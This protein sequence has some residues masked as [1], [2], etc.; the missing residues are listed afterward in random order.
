[1]ERTK[2]L[3]LLGLANRAGK[4]VS[5][6]SEVLHKLQQEKIMMVFVAN[7]ASD[8]TKQTFQNKCTHYKVE[9][10]LDFST[11]E[12]SHA[13]GKEM[14]KILAVTDLGFYKTLKEKL[15]RGE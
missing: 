11:E 10:Y 8:K 14:R 12:L 2:I 5:G 13:I 6:Y 1:M 3:Q 7:D 4:I 15:N 9:L